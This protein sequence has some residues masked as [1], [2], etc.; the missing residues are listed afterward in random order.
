MDLAVVHQVSPASDQVSGQVS[1]EV[2]DGVSQVS[3]QVITLR[4]GR[5]DCERA[6][7]KRSVVMSRMLSVALG[8]DQHAAHVTLDVSGSVLRWLADYMHHHRDGEP[9]AVDFPLRSK[10]M[11]DM[12]SDPWDALFVDQV[13]VV[14]VALA[15]FYLDMQVL[16]HLCCAKLATDLWHPNVVFKKARI[17]Q[18]NY[19]A[20]Y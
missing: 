19:E 9:D 14:D 5:D 6:V 4:S 8:S 17:D 3:D 2:S 10:R 18:S 20:D 16:L 15:A 13:C 7:P 11:A 12:C 1:D